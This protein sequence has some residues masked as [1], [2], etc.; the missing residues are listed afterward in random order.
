MR[1]YNNLYAVDEIFINCP[2]WDRFTR[3]QFLLGQAR[4]TIR[5]QSLSY[6]ARNENIHSVRTVFW[7]NHHFNRGSYDEDGNIKALGLYG[8]WTVNHVDDRLL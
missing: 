4:F 5:I 1:N 7:V 3:R 6:T 2:D 8:D